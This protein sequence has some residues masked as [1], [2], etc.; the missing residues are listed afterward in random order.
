ML[1]I[2]SLLA[3]FYRRMTAAVSHGVTAQLEEL[4][5]EQFSSVC[6]R[7][8]IAV[9]GRGGTADIAHFQCSARY[10]VG[11][12]WPMLCESALCVAASAV[13]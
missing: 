9:W 4:S 8:A 1:C 2:C 6:A 7:Q 12:G 5:L 3:A 13:Y 11:S 10:Q